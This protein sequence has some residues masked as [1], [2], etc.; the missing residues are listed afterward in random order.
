MES[1][2]IVV[3]IYEE[4][5]VMLFYLG[6]I[7]AGKPDPCVDAVFNISSLQFGAWLFQASPL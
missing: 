3:L 6:R 5:L 1:K 4:E 7:I 2:L